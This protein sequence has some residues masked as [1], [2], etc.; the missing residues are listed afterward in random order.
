MYT[1]KKIINVLVVV[2]FVSV[3]VPAFTQE[4]R[5]I[6]RFEAAEMIEGEWEQYG[7]QDLDRGD[8]HIFSE[9][10][11]I[12]FFP[13]GSYTV[14][15]SSGDEQQGSWEVLEIDH[16]PWIRMSLESV[17]QHRTFRI[18]FSN[19]ELKLHDPFILSGVKGFD[20]ELFRRPER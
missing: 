16:R 8:S 14:E 15:T 20:T 17:R 11:F 3:L 19:G 7:S 18:I 12:E 5:Y 4:S 13:D 2:L 6:S 1:R 10:T 9:P